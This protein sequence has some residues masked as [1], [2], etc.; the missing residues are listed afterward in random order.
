MPDIRD[1]LAQ[2]KQARRGEDHGTATD[3]L[4]QIRLSRSGGRSPQPAGVEP[5]P[6]PGGIGAFESDTGAPAPFPSPMHAGLAAMGPQGFDPPPS[7]PMPMSGQYGMDLAQGPQPP[8][9]PGSS[10]QG[11]SFEQPGGVN[12]LLQ[13]LARKYLMGGEGEEQAQAPQ[14]PQLVQQNRDP[15]RVR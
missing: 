8:G 5:A 1:L 4:D 10:I 15:R 14:A 6:S 3:L 13:D 11:M 7:V 9:P 12:P 2:Y